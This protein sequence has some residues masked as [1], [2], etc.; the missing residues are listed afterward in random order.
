MHH[1]CLLEGEAQ[2]KIRFGQ[3]RVNF[4]IETNPEL[5]LRDTDHILPSDITLFTLGTRIT[6][7]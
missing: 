3:V 5:V 1:E 6:F 2:N 7:V 4:Q